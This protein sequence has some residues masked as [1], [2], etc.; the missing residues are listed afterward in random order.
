VSRRKL[1]SLRSVQSPARRYLSEVLRGI[2]G[3]HRFEN[4]TAQDPGVH[5][6]STRRMTRSSSGKRSLLNALPYSSDASEN[7]A[8]FGFITEPGRDIRDNLND[9]YLPHLQR[10][11]CASQLFDNQTDASGRITARHSPSC[12]SSGCPRTWTWMRPISSRV[13]GKGG[14]RK[15][16]TNADVDM[17][18]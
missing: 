12:K 14:N 5:S 6:L 2:D 10:H 8:D 18:G 4:R 3:L 1:R 7:W 17:N 16:T 13:K 11:F 9:F 15:D